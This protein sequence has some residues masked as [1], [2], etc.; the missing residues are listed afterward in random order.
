VKIEFLEDGTLSASPLKTKNSGEFTGLAFSDG[1]VEL[2]QE[3]SVFRKGES[4]RFFPWGP[5]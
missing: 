4:Y 5:L 1:F 2:P 3:K